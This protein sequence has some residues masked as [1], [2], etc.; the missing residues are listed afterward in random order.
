[1]KIARNYSSIRDRDKRIYSISGTKISSTGFSVSYLK[2]FAGVFFFINILGLIFVKISGVNYY[3]PFRDNEIRPGFL[4]FLVGISIG[5][6]Y[7]L[8]YQKVQNY[9][10]IDYLIGYFMPKKSLNKNKNRIKE[11]GYKVDALVERI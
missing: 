7:V 3:N 6:S 11:G 8:V 1:M 4:I 5:I 10:M 2:V 9:R